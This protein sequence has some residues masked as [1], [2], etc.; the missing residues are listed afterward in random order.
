MAEAMSL[1][2]LDEKIK[3]K[4][5]KVSE[6]FD[7]CPKDGGEYKMTAEQIGE[8]RGLNAELK[9]LTPQFEELKGIQEMRSR[10]GDR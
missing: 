6:I 1:R 9:E 10:V 7:A 2:E 3:A 5:A 8:V 4:R